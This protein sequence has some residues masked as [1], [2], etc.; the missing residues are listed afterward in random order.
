MPEIIRELQLR[1]Y[2][3]EGEIILWSAQGCEACNNTGY[4][5]RSAI[6]EVLVLDDSLRRLVLKHADG[7]TLQE[8]AKQTG[9]Q[10]LYEDGLIKAL[11]GTTTLEEILRVAEESH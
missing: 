6:H 8:Q 11:A 9:M 7:G 2:Q 4:K 5:G 3:P 10:T 1:K